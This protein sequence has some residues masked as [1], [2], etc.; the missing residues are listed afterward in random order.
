MKIQFK[1]LLFSW[2]KLDLG[3]KPFAVQMID[4]KFTH[5]REENN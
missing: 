5:S 3:V 1:N 2:S 4:V